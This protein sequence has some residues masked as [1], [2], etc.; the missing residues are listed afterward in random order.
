LTVSGL[1]GIVVQALGMGNMN[2]S[3]YEGVKYAVSKNIPVVISTRVLNG[4]VMGSYGFI[5]G[6]KTTV[7]AGAVM[8]DDLR[9]QK[10]RILLMLLLQQGTK[11]QKSLQQAFDK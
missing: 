9:A 6:G 5:G 1:N 7:D 2:E 3:M 4:R 11:D 8:A 10:A